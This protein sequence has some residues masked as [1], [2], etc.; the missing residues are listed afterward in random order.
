VTKRGALALSEWL[1]TNYRSKGIKVSCFCPGA[2][3]T[4]MLAANGLAPD[5]PALRN[6]HTPE[7]VADIIVRGIRA[8][9]FL[10][11]TNP[12][13]DQVLR[14]KAEDYDAW[15]D[16]KLSSYEDLVGALPQ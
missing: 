8:E 6:A 4:R 10:I 11:L 13:D 15:L 12:N 9:K 14:E 2:M 1:A 7:Q 16:A 5:S 3:R